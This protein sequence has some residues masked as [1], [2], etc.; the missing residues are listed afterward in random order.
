MLLE[1]TNEELVEID[2]EISDT[3]TIYSIVSIKERKENSN[4]ENEDLLNDLAVA[5][6]EFLGTEFM[7]MTCEH[8]WKNNKG[9]DSIRWFKCKWF[10]DRLNR[11]KC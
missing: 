11:A 10:L 8:K 5:E 3:Q 1:C 4:S 2:E 6:L 9:L 7:D